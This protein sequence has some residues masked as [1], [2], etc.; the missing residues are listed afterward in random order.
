[1]RGHEKMNESLFERTRYSRVLP[2]HNNM[3]YLCHA[4]RLRLAI[5]RFRLRRGTALVDYQTIAQ[6]CSLFVGPYVAH[7]L[8]RW[9]SGN[10]L[11][12]VNYAFYKR[13][14]SRIDRTS[15]SSRLAAASGLRTLPTSRL[16]VRHRCDLLLSSV[17]PN[18]YCLSHWYDRPR[19]PSSF[20]DTREDSTTSSPQFVCAH[21]VHVLKARPDDQCTPSYSTQCA[22]GFF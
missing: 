22:L 9:L 3:D 10:S 4:V 13:T 1:M 20:E 19:V 21:S 18:F 5:H 8:H 6:L 12:I 14:T 15:P 2:K 7:H 11:L 16:I 17:R